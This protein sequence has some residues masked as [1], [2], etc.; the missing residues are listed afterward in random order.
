MAAAEENSSLRACSVKTEKTKKENGRGLPLRLW[1]N[2]I[3]TILFHV[4][5]RWTDL[6]PADFLLTDPTDC[7]SSR[8]LKRVSQPVLLCWK[9]DN[10]SKTQ[11]WNCNRITHHY[12]NT[13]SF[14][15]AHAIYSSVC[16][17][18]RWI[19]KWNHSWG[20]T[21]K[22]HLLSTSKIPRI[23]TWTWSLLK[24]GNLGTILTSFT[25]HDS[26]HIVP[27]L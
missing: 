15:F 20:K 21:V 17:R 2:A 27:N 11:D 16:F 4:P 6:D 5:Q 22:F 18:T 14:S 3:H 24:F 9:R 25:I 12:I 13:L 23:H 19:H 26:F 10:G 1:L 7:E 8:R